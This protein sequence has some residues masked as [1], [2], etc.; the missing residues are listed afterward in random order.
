MNNYCVYCHTTPSGRKYV[1]ISCDP[2]KR[3]NSGKGYSLNYIFY[4]AIKK[5][6]WNNIKH[7][8]LFENLSE[9]EAKRKEIELIN[10]WHL[11]DRKYGYNLQTGG[12]GPF[13]EST[14]ARMSLARIGNLNCRGRKLSDSTKTKISNS[15]KDYYS[16]HTPTFLGKK[17]KSSTIQMLKQ[18]TFSEETRL[19]MRKSH[20]DVSGAN[21]PSAKSVR[22]IAL[23]GTCLQE[24]AYAK[25]AAIENG[26]DLSAII[27]CC[28]GKVKSCGGFRWEYIK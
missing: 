14:K 15:L 5:Y 19:K 8:I 24:Y 26:L 13:S 23:D 27:K 3:W 4:R 7:E 1:G 6:G 18:R 10:E 28:R 21:N 17:H 16:T 12:G 9:E 25:L 20:H 2:L 11:I 22:K